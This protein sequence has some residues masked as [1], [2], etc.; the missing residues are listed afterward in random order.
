MRAAV[1]RCLLSSQDARKVHIYIRRFERICGLR[2]LFI[3]QVLIIDKCPAEWV[4]GNG[5]FTAGAHRIVHNGLEDILPLVQNAPVNAAAQIEMT[6]YTREDFVSDIM[7]LGGNKS[8][9]AMVDAVVDNSQQ[10]VRWLAERVGIPFTLSFNRQA[11]EVN[12]K[13]KF[14]GGLVLSVEDGGKGLIAAHQRALKKAGVEIWFN[15]PA[16]SLVAKDGSIAG[17]IVRKNGEELELST[18]TVILAA[19]GF[20]ANADMRVKHLGAG[21]ENAR[22]FPFTQLCIVCC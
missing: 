19:G 7:R 1:R 9:P 18:P 15:T 4:G 21:W 13:Q 22:V 12:G 10:A 5:Y 20:E 16:L 8:D 14:W 17:I 11:Y 3:F 6:P 2:D